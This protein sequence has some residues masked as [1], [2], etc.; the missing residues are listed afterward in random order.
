MNYTGVSRR[1]KKKPQR[2]SWQNFACDVLIINDFC[3]WLSFACF[4]GNTD[5]PTE[6]KKNIVMELDVSRSDSLGTYVM[7]CFRYEPAKITLLNTISVF[8]RDVYE[9]LTWWTVMGKLSK[10]TFKQETQILRISEFFSV[11][12]ILYAR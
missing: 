1:Y 7:S 12:T 11:V 8:F 5:D 3:S 6:A 4:L 9:S 2:I 10:R